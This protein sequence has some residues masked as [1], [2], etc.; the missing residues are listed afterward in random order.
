MSLSIVGYQRWIKFKR[1]LDLALLTLSPSLPHLILSVC[2]SLLLSITLF[3]SRRELQ[4]N[5]GPLTLLCILSCKLTV[6]PSAQPAESQARAAAPA[7]LAS[8][9]QVWCCI[10]VYC[11]DTYAILFFLHQVH[12]LSVPWL[13]TT[14]STKDLFHASD[15]HS[16]H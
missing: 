1:Y 9:D 2:L 13:G 6:G 15:E 10:G 16:T 14:D 7:L 4:H 11:T 8:A 5:V 12:L 3:L